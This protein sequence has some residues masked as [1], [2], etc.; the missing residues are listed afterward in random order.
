M[1]S[2]WV[3]SMRILLIVLWL[4][5]DNYDIVDYNLLSE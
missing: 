1:C 4:K 2:M 3:K 5:D